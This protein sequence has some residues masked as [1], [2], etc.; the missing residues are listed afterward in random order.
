M[1]SVLTAFVDL[2]TTSQLPFFHKR[3]SNLP[4]SFID[5]NSVQTERAAITT[6][7][8]LPSLKTLEDCAEYSKVVEPYIQQLYDLPQGVYHAA[9]NSHSPLLELYI[10]TNPLISGF[11]F[12]LFLGSVFLV[13]SEANRNYSQVDRMW[14]LLPTIYNA[15]FAIWAHLNKLPS[16][17]V[18]LIL[19]WSALW[20]VC[21]TKPGLRLLY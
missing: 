21:S 9:T 11:G 12:S 15:H 20:S 13:V 4:F 16:Q 5:T 17:R 19:L 1:F 14:S 7:M 6:T 18:D 2:R 10:N 3:L 8:A